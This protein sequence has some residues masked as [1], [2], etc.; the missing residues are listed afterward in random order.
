MHVVL[1]SSQAKGAWSMLHPKHQPHV[2][3]RVR[4][5]ARRHG[6]RL[7]RY[8][9]VGNHL[10]LLVKTRT[11]TALKRFLRELSG[12]VAVI[13]TGA[14]RGRAL[15]ARFWDFI[16][17]TRIVAWG[18]DFL[19]L[20]TYFVKNFFEAAGLLTRKIKAEGYEI[21]SMKGWGEGPP[22]L[23]IAPGLAWSAGRR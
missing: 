9:N 21:I 16:P 15:K 18:R 2:D 1:R 14:Q 22:G 6:I 20:D 12:T 3:R 11:R 23:P 7:Y 19:N 10:H 4:E 8:T 5:I 13:V 17:Y